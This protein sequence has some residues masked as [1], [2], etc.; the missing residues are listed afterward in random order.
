MEEQNASNEIEIITPDQAEE[1]LRPEIEKLVAEGWR[2][3]RRPL[4]GVRLARERDLLDLRVDLLGVIERTEGINFSY[5]PDIGRLVAW[6]LL[7]TSLL[8]ALTLASALG[9]L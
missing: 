2:V 7:I 9:W 5:G 6:M 4:Y 3:V 8:L 1:I